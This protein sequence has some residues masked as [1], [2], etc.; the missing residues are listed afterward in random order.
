MGYLG[1]RPWLFLSDVRYHSQP[2]SLVKPVRLRITGWPASR[3]VA[4]SK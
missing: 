3:A 1:V 2:S 4:M